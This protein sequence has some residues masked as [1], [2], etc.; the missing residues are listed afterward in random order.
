MDHSPG[1]GCLLALT[2]GDCAC[3]MHW[4]NAASVSAMSWIGLFFTVWKYDW[5]NSWSP[6]LHVG[7]KDTCACSPAKS[8]LFG[9]VSMMPEHTSGWYPRHIQSSRCAHIH[10]S[11][12]NQSM[13]RVINA[14]ESSHT[15]LSNCVMF[16]I[17]SFQYA[18]PQDGKECAWK[19][20]GICIFCSGSTCAFSRRKPSLMLVC[21][22]GMVVA[23]ES[24]T[25]G[26]TLT[27]CNARANAIA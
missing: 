3:V 15:S 4:P 7:L 17:C 16:Q 24:T 19:L 8:A 9:K 26:K 22:S 13:L 23:S 5:I 20:A 14:S 6:C 25:S 27:R 12:N 1:T 11:W 10:D 2:Y 21:P 18:T